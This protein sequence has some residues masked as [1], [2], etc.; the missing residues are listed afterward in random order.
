MRASV[1]SEIGLLVGVCRSVWVRGKV[2]VRMRKSAFVGTCVGDAGGA[3]E[4]E[5]GLEG[6]G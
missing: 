2:S 5:G 4:A 1:Q 3:E 6:R